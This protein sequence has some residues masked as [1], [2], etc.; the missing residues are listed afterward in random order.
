MRSKNFVNYSDLISFSRA[1]NATF[2]DANGVLQTAGVN[3][4]RIDHDPD[5]G[6]AKGLLIEPERTNLLIDS[7]SLAT[8]SVTVT[9]E[10]YVLH[11]QGAGSVEL[12]GAFAETLSGT[13]ESDRVRLVFTPSAGTL[14][15]TV[16][17]N[18]LNAQLEAGE[19]PTSYIPTASFEE[20]R[21][22][23]IAEIT[24][25]DFAGWHNDAEGT[26]LVVSGE[27]SG[28]GIVAQLDDGSDDNRITYRRIF[29]GANVE[30]VLNGKLQINES[31]NA[32]I[33]QKDFLAIGYDLN[34]IAYSLNG[35]PATENFEFSVPTQ[36]ALRIGSG[37]SSPESI[38]YLKAIQYWPRKLNN[39]DLASISEN[40]SAEPPGEEIFSQVTWDASTDTYTQDLY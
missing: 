27:Y 33:E 2:Y 22:A 5:T 16:T 6:V 1:S 18:V 20:T 15:V 35:F 8:Q 21:S 26:L 30:S 10:K 36:I 31:A 40:P 11:F 28:N 37:S 17:G 29:G 12:S 9:N 14:T 4:P 7:A 23:D 38:T 24:G 39:T 32:L 3:E 13:A 34:G 25:P 19:F